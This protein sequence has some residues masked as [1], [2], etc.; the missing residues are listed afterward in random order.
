MSA[1]NAS[2]KKPGKERHMTWSWGTNMRQTQCFVVLHM[3]S[4]TFASARKRCNGK[5]QPLGPPNRLHNWSSM[6]NI[7]Q[8]SF[9]K[10]ESPD[11]W[12]SSLPISSHP[13]RVEA[14]MYTADM[15]IK[16][17]LNPPVW[18][19]C[20]KTPETSQKIRPLSCMKHRALGWSSHCHWTDQWPVRAM[21]HLAHLVLESWR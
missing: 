8:F 14:T 10:Y 4:V 2:G 15:L 1:W 13:C 20:P 3:A 6:S 18:E 19:N 21:Q 17:C 16:W 5:N 9:A 7:N 11:W 12:R